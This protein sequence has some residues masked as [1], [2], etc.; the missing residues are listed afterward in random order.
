MGNGAWKKKKNKIGKREKRERRE[1]KEI[2]KIPD[3][4]DVQGEN[5]GLVLFRFHMQL[6]PVFFELF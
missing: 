4:K 3:W 1:K 2:W 5:V 6:F